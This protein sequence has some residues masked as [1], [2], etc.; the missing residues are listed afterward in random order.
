MNGTFVLIPCPDTAEFD[1]AAFLQ[2]IQQYLG[3]R[4]ETALPVGYFHD[5]TIKPLPSGR[6]GKALDN[7]S[8]IFSKELCITTYPF[9]GSILQR[10]PY[11][12]RNRAP[13]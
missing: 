2:L 9:T 6:D 1:K 12:N 11:F 3:S 10:K 13:A 5:I 7:K 8:G 4:R